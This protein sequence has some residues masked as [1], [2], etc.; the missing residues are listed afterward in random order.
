[1]EDFKF[2]KICGKKIFKKD[3]ILNPYNPYN[4]AAWE[5]RKFCKA[6]CRLI[7]NKKEFKYKL[8]ETYHN[9]QL[10]KLNEL[11]KG[12]INIVQSIP[13]KENED[14][15]TEDTNYEFELLKG[16]SKFKNKYKKYKDYKKKHIL[17]IGI[18]PKLKEMFDEVYCYNIEK[19]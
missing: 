4:D 6:E 8:R 1:M 17:I 18:H 5:R 12:K 7:N 11:I 19:F 15:R 10:I 14:I 2:C 16:L 13:G 9:Q 3:F